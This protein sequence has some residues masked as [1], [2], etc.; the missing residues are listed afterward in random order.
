M[1]LFSGISRFIK[2]TVIPRILPVATGFL[3]GGPLGAGAALALPEFFDPSAL[4]AGPPR[5]IRP[6]IPGTAA[7]RAPGVVSAAAPGG[8]GAFF[9]RFLGGLSG[10]IRTPDIVAD[11]ASRVRTRGP[12]SIAQQQRQPVFKPSLFGPRP[13]L[14]QPDQPRQVRGFIR[15]SFRVFQPIFSPTGRLQNTSRGM[16]QFT[17]PAFS[18][19]RG[20]F[21]GIGGRFNI[22]GGFRTGGTPGARAARPAGPQRFS[23]RQQFTAM[24]L[25]PQPVR[26]GFFA[27]RALPARLPLATSQTAVRAQFIPT[28][29]PRKLGVQVQSQPATNRFAVLAARNKARA[30]TEQSRARTVALVG[31][32]GALVGVAAAAGTVAT[33][34]SRF[35]SRRRR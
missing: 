9:T 20:I 17:Q 8:F 23:G 1:G 29:S 34:I 26:R 14:A 35:F 33:G 11:P 24:E 32:A 3:T 25:R 10:G 13:A 2:K 31:G 18:P 16:F 21:A 4:I 30:V 6:I 22:F 15:P 5:A 28:P 27:T 12:Q 7:A 19:F